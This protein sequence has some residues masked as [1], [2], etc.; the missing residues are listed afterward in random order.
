VTRN[1]ILQSHHLDIIP[2]SGDVGKITVSGH[3]PRTSTGHYLKSGGKRVTIRVDYIYNIGINDNGK[4]SER[5][6]L[7]L[8]A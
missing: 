8:L 2:V 4:T 3:I 6:N 1:W 5:F 7:L